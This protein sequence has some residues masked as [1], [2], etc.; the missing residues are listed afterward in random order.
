MYWGTVLVSIHA[1]RRRGANYLR[2]GYGIRKAWIS[3]G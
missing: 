1:P 3:R 2:R